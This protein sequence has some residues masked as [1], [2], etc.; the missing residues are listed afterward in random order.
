MYVPDIRV[1]VLVNFYHDGD[2]KPMVFKLNGA[3]YNIKKATNIAR[4]FLVELDDG[5]T[6]ELKYDIEIGAWFIKSDNKHFIHHE[7]R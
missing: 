4:N 2:I 5:T 7:Q 6:A 1:D 3:R